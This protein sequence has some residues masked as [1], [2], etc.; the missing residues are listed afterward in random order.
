MI[1]IAKAKSLADE[2]AWQQS[3][4][5][6]ALCSHFDG[7]S[8]HELI[9]MWTSSRNLEGKALQPVRNASHR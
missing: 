8:P 6:A 7:T 9:A 4:H 1:S 3:D 5:E 2:W